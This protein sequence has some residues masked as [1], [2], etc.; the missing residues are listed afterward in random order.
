[1]G[2]GNDWLMDT[3]SPTPLP[4]RGY[5]Q[6]PCRAAEKDANFDSPV[7]NP[8]IPILERVGR[9]PLDFISILRGSVKSREKVQNMDNREWDPL[10]YI[11]VMSIIREQ[12]KSTHFGRIRR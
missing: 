1:M 3:A 8:G 10:W 6:G 2:K 5:S 4:L 12:S 11:A 7:R 9:L